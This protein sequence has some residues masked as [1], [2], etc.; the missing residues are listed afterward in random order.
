LKLLISEMI[1]CLLLF[2]GFW[3]ITNSWKIRWTKGKLFLFKEKF[4]NQNQFVL[5]G[6]VIDLKFF[7]IF[8][9]VILAIN[10]WWMGLWLCQ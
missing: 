1:S 2:S 8:L 10:H 7:L 3:N 6:I 4:K 9:C 5:N